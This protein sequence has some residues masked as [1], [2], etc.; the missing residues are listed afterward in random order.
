MPDGSVRRGRRCRKHLLFEN[1]KLCY[2]AESDNTKE[3]QL[4]AASDR[5]LKETKFFIWIRCN[6]L[7][8]PESAKGIQGNPSFFAWFYL[9]LLGFIWPPSRTRVNAPLLEQPRR[10]TGQSRQA[11]PQAGRTA[12]R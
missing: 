6:P 12:A 3:P 11:L 4:G 5:L 2:S 10:R 9:D 7:K 1:R 8:S